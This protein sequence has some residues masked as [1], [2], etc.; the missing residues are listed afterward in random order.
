MPT[1][2]SPL[3]ASAEDPGPA[4]RLAMCRLLLDEPDRQG[5]AS[6]PLTACALEIERGGLSY[7]VDTLRSVHARL[8]DAPLRFIVGAD[9]AATLA[10]WREP[11]EV[12]RLAELI[13]AGRGESTRAGVLEALSAVGDAGSEGARVHF[14]EMAPVAISSSRVRELA[15]RGEPTAA[16]VGAGVSDYIEREGLYREEGR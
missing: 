14:L 11:E 12:L 13:V 8:P 16:L 4:H 15:A 3:K 9:T 1:H 7:T 10:S 6:V 2:T 5:G